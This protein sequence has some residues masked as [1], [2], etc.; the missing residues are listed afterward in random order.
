MFSYLSPDAR[1][2]DR[3]PLRP[4]RAKVGQAL[5]RD[6]PAMARAEMGLGFGGLAGAWLF[7]SHALDFEPWTLN[8]TGSERLFVLYSANPPTVARIIAEKIDD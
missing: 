3:H 1:V 7:V 8:R 5:A 6:D 2:L 4:I